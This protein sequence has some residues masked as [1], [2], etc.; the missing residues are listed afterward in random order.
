MVL[1]GSSEAL[2][3]QP[4]V[5]VSKTW[6]ANQ[7][8]GSSTLVVVTMPHQGDLIYTSYI[9][10]SGYCI[11]RQESRKES[12]K[13]IFESAAQQRGFNFP[14]QLGWGKNGDQPILATEFNHQVKDGDIIILGTDGVFDNLSPSNVGI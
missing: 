6:M 11:L 9:G 13:I 7:E 3:T 5:L 1:D 8:D 2:L 10:D 14:Y 4:K 12:Y